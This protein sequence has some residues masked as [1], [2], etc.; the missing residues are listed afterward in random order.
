MNYMAASKY[1]KVNCIV[2]II[3]VHTPTIGPAQPDHDE[4][5]SVAHVC[6]DAVKAAGDTDKFIT[7]L[8]LSLT[9][10]YSTNFPILPIKRAVTLMTD[11][12]YCCCWDLT[13][14]LGVDI[15]TASHPVHSIH[16]RR[17]YIHHTKKPQM[18]WNSWLW[19][20]HLLL[21][22]WEVIAGCLK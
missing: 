16:P 14:A 19:L 3:Q 22:D 9:L 18:G 1:F 15:E 4:K 8:S 21:D 12:L 17:Q 10:G 7:H 11:S 20:F 5:A 6:S 13:V 2:Y